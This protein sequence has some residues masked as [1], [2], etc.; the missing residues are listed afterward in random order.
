MLTQFCSV[1]ISA[2]SVL[3]TVIVDTLSLP[4]D[5]NSTV[6]LITSAV[7][8]FLGEGSLTSSLA[9][10]SSV[11]VDSLTATSLFRLSEYLAHPIIV[12]SSPHFEQDILQTSTVLHETQWY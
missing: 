1:L 5:E 7:F 6:V 11:K 2:E 4:W 10:L 8:H 3:A 9:V 12:S